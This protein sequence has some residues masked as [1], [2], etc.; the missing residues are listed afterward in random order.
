MSPANNPGKYDKEVFLALREWEPFF[1]PEEDD[2]DDATALPARSRSARRHWTPARAG[3][4][5]ATRCF[6]STESRWARANRSACRQGD[7]V[8]MHLLNAS[9]SMN[10][11]IA[12][13]GHRFKIVALDG[14]PVPT[15]QTVDVIYI[16]PGE[17]VDAIVEMN[18]PGVWILGTTTDDV[19]NAGMGVIDRI[20]ESAQA[21]AVGRARRNRFG[22]TRFLAATWT[23]PAPD[24][25]I[26]MIFRKVPSGAGLF[27]SWTVNG[28]EYPHD[29]EFVLKQGGRY[30][31]VFRNR[32]EDDH[33]LHMHR[34]SFE[35]VEINGKTTG[36]I[37]KDTVIVPGYGRATV[38]MVADQPGLTLFHCHIQQHMDYG[39]KALFR[40]A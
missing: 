31:L 28:K 7:R 25:T 40:Y 23:Q 37:M 27:N 20:R 19:R 34:H 36:G 39:F 11:S 35:L 33:P 9:A 10:R 1:N 24:Q 38:D 2:D 22:I 17:R 8:L 21:A 15:P 13:P 18:Q 14:N 32:S 5:W 4:K 3:S 16:G 30:R 26:D 29:R 6:R 12:L